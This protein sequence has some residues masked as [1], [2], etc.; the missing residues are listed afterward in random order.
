M[1]KSFQ[2]PTGR[3]F[4]AKTGVA[5]EPMAEAEKSD[6]LCL[7]VCTAGAAVMEVDMRTYDIRPRTEVVMLFGTLLRIMSVSPDFRCS[8]LAYTHKFISEMGLRLDLDLVKHLKLNPVMDLREADYDG[9]VT[10][11]YSL[12]ATL[13]GRDS[14]PRQG[15][16]MVSLLRLYLDDI[17]DNCH[18]KWKEQ[19]Q[20]PTDRQTD[21]FRRF[22]DMVRQK[23]AENREVEYYADRLSITPRYLSQICQLR[24]TSPKRIIDESVTFAA[25]EM[26][27]STDTSIQDIASELNF[28]DQS[29][30]TRFFRRM[31]GQSPREWRKSVTGRG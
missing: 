27:H 26:L 29:V 22:L 17:H 10:H 2:L 3:N 23:S 19:P 12:A 4:M 14:D 5:F 18:D 21:L 15:Q 11:V 9:V 13:S 1:I 25:K 24:H 7:F 6:D 30:F 20:Q 16:K 8:I 28:A 31:T